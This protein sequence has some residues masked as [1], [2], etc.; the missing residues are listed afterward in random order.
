MDAENSRHP[1]GGKREGRFLPGGRERRGIS[2]PGEADRGGGP[3]DREPHLLSSEP[4]ALLAGAHPA[5][6]KR[7][8]ASPGNHYRTFDDAFPAAL[9]RRYEPIKDH[10]TDSVAAGPGPRLPRRP[11][12]H[13]STG[14]GAAGR[15]YYP[16]T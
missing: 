8:A 11:G 15:G 16:P 6:T 2:G 13:R 12:E 7:D 9:R 14:L 3:R 10:G 5:R 4:G 1:E